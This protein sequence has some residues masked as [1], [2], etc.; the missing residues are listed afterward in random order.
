[1]T[2]SRADLHNACVRA[3]FGL[4]LIVIAIVAG[5]AGRENTPELPA[6]ALDATR[7]ASCLGPETP[8]PDPFLFVTGAMPDSGPTLKIGLRS[9]CRGAWQISTDHSGP[10]VRMLPRPDAATHLRTFP[11]LI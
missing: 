9:P 4:V 6:G 3:F 8:P 1:L 5:S 7:T 2:P 10:A 11:L